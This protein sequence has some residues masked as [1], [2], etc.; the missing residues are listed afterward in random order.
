MRLFHV[1]EE[2]DIPIF[3]PRLPSRRDLDPAIGLVW[4]IDESHLPNFL[5][6]RDCPRVAWHVGQG[7]SEADRHR[8][9]S[10]TTH[11]YA[12]AFE[13]K[14]LEAMRHTTLYL[15]EFSPDGFCLQDGIA[16]YHVSTSA[17]TPI[18]RHS[19]D[20]PLG[21]LIRRGV[22]VRIVDNLWHI[23]DEIKSSTLDWSLCRMAN[24]LPRRASKTSDC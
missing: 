15:Y 18:A 1:S 8:F 9:F 2:P 21:E 7:T 3:H 10:S 23:A 12:V 13:G 14:W 4:A 17:Q 16:G 5:T 19:I 24:A 6:P 20:D 11:T 22:E